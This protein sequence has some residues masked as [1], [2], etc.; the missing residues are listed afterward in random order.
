MCLFHLLCV[1][2]IVIKYFRFMP[3]EIFSTNPWDV[4]ILSRFYFKQ[5][6]GDE[7]TTS[8]DIKALLL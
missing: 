1:N 2:I 4:H 3:E 6:L 8:T 7:M 5:V